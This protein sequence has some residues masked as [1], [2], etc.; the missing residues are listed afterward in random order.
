MVSLFLVVSVGNQ[1][2]PDGSES[3]TA[4]VIQHNVTSSTTFSDRSGFDPD[5]WM[6]G[7]YLPVLNQM[8]ANN[9]LKVRSQ[10]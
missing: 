9:N 6:L 7:P 10:F 8:G 4:L 5:N 2:P 3:V 1:D